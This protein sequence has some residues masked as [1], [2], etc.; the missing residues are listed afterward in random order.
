MKKTD[1]VLRQLVDWNAAFW[2]GILS[3]VLA[4]TISAV[5]TW[6]LLGSPMVAFRIIASVVRGP[7]VL[8]PVAGDDAGVI[9][10]ALFV[11]LAI[12]L[13]FALI[14]A[15][16]VHRWGLLVSFVG[17][18]LLGLALYVINFYS[19]SFFFPWLFAY[20]SWIFMVAHI[21]FGAVAGVIYELLEVETFVP[22][23]AK[24][25]KR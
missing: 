10:A 21:T 9:L 5:I 18:G 2:A 3:G 16:V 20:R 19:I 17:G 13:V 11:Q 8:Q 7:S 22:V 25:K 6:R 4:L 1:T 14:T 12:A 24:G 23:M 15:V